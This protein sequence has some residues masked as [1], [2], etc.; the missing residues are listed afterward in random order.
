MR[1]VF[2]GTPAFALPSLDAL[3]KTG[4][5]VVA[6][7]SQP[8]KRKGRGRADTPPPVKE[9]ALERGIEV[10][11]PFKITDST[12]LHRLSLLKPD[13]IVVIAYG[14]ILRAPILMLPPYGCI[15]V[16]ASLLP[17]YR[18]AAPI[19]WA[20]I[21]GDVKTGITTMIMDEGL[22]TG[23]ILLQEETDIYRDDTAESLGKRLSEMSA[24]VL[25][26]TLQGIEQRTLSPSPQVGTPSFA[27]PLKKE[28]GVI[29]WSKTAR[30]VHNFI[31]GMYPWPCAYCYLNGE[32]IKI[33]K[34]IALEGSG[35]PRKIQKAGNELIVGT[36]N[37]LISILEL[38]PEGKKI[39]SA[40]AFLQGRRLKEGTFFDEPE[41]DERHHT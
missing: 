32:R 35:Q 26:K 4:E 18:G 20:I 12:L 11:Q 39:M 19:Q 38:Q 25:L 22:D 10:L 13:A 9:Y 33:I 6:V 29:D 27:P 23:D 36:G 37:G 28:D 17:N 14:K 15:N 31:R 41:M 1:I 7:V 24:P 40:K 2:F 21:H 16:H 3:L 30:A 34:A 5:D 8:D